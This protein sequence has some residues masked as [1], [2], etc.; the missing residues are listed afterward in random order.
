MKNTQN[1]IEDTLKLIAQKGYKNSNKDF[2][3]AFAEFL[4]GLFDVDYVL[5]NTYFL[6]TPT[7]TETVVVYGK[8][9]ILPNIKY[10]LVGTPCENV[11]NKNSCAYPNKIQKLFPKD[12]LLTQMNVESYI[13]IPLWSSE[14][15]PIGL[16]AILDS[17]PITDTKTVETI[18]QIGAIKSAQVI[19]QLLFK[20]TLKQRIKNVESEKKQKLESEERY[21]GLSDASFNAIFISENGFCLEQ[22]AAAEKMFGYSLDEIVGMK[23]TDIIAPKDHELVMSNIVSGNEA[24]YEVTAIRKDRTTFP[25][26][27]QARTASYK[28]KNVRISAFRNLS[29]RNELET[30]IKISEEKFK[31]LSNLTFEGILIHDRG[32]AIDINLSFAKMFGYKSKELVGENIVDILFPKKYYKQILKI[33]LKRSHYLMK[34]KEYEKM[35]LFSL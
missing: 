24:P 27:I 26:A 4:V 29:Y 18:L 20:S 30:T 3:N 28:G 21:R 32:V 34:L 11:I 1:L 17:K 16:I 8:N 10:N 35:V 14:G 6:E 2:L 12:E 22:N 9:G 15:K 25:V 5:I 33:L 23:A 31:K 19:E 13:G 7:T